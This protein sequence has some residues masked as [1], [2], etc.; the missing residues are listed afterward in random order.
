[1]NSPI[2]QSLLEFLVTLQDSGFLAT[3]K[4]PG[5][6]IYADDQII[7]QQQLKNSFKEIGVTERLFIFPDGQQVIEYFDFLLEDIDLSG[8]E[9]I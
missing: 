1:M 8:E 3:D 2:I 9:Q 7:C 5:L 4:N 6:V